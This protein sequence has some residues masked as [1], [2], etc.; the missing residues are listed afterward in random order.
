MY[1]MRIMRDKFATLQLIQLITLYSI[2]INGIL[3]LRSPVVEYRGID[4]INF[5][6][7]RPKKAKRTRRRLREQ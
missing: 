6:I 1:I 5:H 3:T 4:Y 7:L 2:C